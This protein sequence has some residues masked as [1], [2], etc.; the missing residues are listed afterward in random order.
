[1][2]WR[3]HRCRRCAARLN[4]CAAPRNVHHATHCSAAQNIAAQRC[5]TRSFALQ[6]AATESV[7]ALTWIRG[8]AHVL[9]A[10]FS[11]RRIQIYDTRCGARWR[12]ERTAPG[13][14]GTRKSR[15]GEL[16]RACAW[17][18]VASACGAGG[19]RRAPAGHFAL[20]RSQPPTPRCS[21]C[22]QRNGRADCARR[23]AG[24]IRAGRS[25]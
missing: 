10:G 15:Y 2:R 12:A 5:A 24:C 14:T 11:F 21:D 16:Q 8:S 25:R 19:H 3:R 1:M 22:R 4:Q 23:P 18:I 13:G 6:L 9:A 17:L 7:N 20:G